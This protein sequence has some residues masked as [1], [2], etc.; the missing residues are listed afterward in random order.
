MGDSRYHVD[1]CCILADAA[2]CAVSCVDDELVTTGSHRDGHRP[3]ELCERCRTVDQPWLGPTRESAGCATE[4]DIADACR[5]LMRDDTRL[6]TLVGP[7]GIGKTRLAIQV[8][9]EVRDAFEDGAF[10]VPLAPIIVLTRPCRRRSVTARPT[11][12][13]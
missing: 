5:R 2:D 3:I 12:C 4:R 8:A 6:L 10:F 13:S 9:A 7:P 1:T 11:R